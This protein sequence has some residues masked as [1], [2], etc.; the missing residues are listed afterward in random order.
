[1]LAAA[2]T[3]TGIGVMSV[4]ADDCAIGTHSDILGDAEAIGIMTVVVDV[5]MD[6]METIVMGTLMVV[7]A[8]N[9]AAFCCFVRSTVANPGRFQ[10]RCGVPRDTFVV[11]RASTVVDVDGVAI[12]VVFIDVVAVV[13]EMIVDVATVVGATGIEVSEQRGFVRRQRSA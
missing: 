10:C 11:V 8:G 5:E 12:D 13:G 1:M 2:N 7:G 3:S 9:L 6:G 4:D